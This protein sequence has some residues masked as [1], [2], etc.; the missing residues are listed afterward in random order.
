MKQFSKLLA[1][2]IALLIFSLTSCEKDL[3]ENQIQNGS[4]NLSVQH[5][6]LKDIEKNL[7]EKI[8]RKINSIKKAN[9]NKVNA[10]GKFEYNSE[11]D[12]YIDTENGELINNNGRISYTFPMFRESEEKL[13]N[14]V[15]NLMP[16]E[17][18]DTYLVKY[19]VS[20]E[21]LQ[22]MTTSEK[23]NLQPEFARF[24][25][26]DNDGLVCFTITASETTY[27]TCQYPNG[28]H[29]NGT[30]CAAEITTISATF[31]SQ[32]AGGGGDASTGQT[33]TGGNYSGNTN[34]NPQGSS[35]SGGSGG[36]NNTGNT[37]GG[38]YGNGG[39]DGTGITT[40]PVVPTTL[41]IKQIKQNFLATANLNQQQLD[42]WNN[43]QNATNV[44]QIVNYLFENQTILIEAQ[45]P[46]EFVKQIINQIIANPNTFTTI[47]PFLIEDQIDDSQ[48]NPCEKDVFDA[49]K[50]TTNND[51]AKVFAKLGADNTIYNTK[52]VSDVAPN[53]APA[54]TVWNTPYN[55]T[56]YVSTN[57]AGKT[58]LFIASAILHEVVHAYFMSLFDDF[59]NGTPN[60]LN[61]YDDFGILFQKYVDGTYPGSSDVAHHEQMANS[62][63]NTI[64]SSLQEFQPGLPQQVYEDLAWGGLQAAPIF[65]IK[66]P[67]GS[68]DRSRIINRYT[69][70]SIGSSYGQGTAQVQVSLGQPC[71]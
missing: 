11:L 51:F 56:I 31:C 21:E 65:S 34:E 33:N 42:W 58:K 46:T 57:Y 40:T 47:T 66:F 69:A 6:K 45:S 60:N 36:Y 15:F 48:L 70:E 7:S 19:N 16:N 23:E 44:N 64:A 1:L 13:E 53:N 28:D 50:N 61:S 71:N 17:E 3:Y 43:P 37:T 35:G 63:V 52:I 29:G 25:Q 20:I 41:T 39:L 22:N 67:V 62:Y 59:H 10:E 9:Q 26:A 2:V 27:G 30:H 32:T 5:V 24:A 55:Y 4:K 12:I 54:Q 18:F 49:I 38:V 14:I 68:D 8:N